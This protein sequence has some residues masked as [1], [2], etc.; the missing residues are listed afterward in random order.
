MAEQNLKS[1]FKS[2]EFYVTLAQSITGIFVMLGYLTPQEADGLAQAIVE[3][4]GGLMIIVPTAI[5]LFGRIALKREQVKN[6]T[7]E[8]SSPVS[9][10]LDRG[11]EA[12]ETPVTVK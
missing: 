7:Q 12:P 3:V 9:S 5:Y 4:I 1:G 6:G 10:V 11:E 2:S 8:T